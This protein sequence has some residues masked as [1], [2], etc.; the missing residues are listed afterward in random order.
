[1]V[2][3]FTN[4]FYLRFPI[5]TGRYFCTNGYTA[6]RINTTSIS[7]TNVYNILPSKCMNLSSLG[8]ITICIHIIRILALEMFIISF[9]SLL[10]SSLQIPKNDMRPQ[11]VDKIPTIPLVLAKI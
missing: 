7:P 2:T 4:S 9:D 1:M 8:T 10:S 6:V 11:P 5:N 3:H